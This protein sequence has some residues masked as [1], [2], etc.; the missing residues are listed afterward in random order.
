[1]YAFILAILGAICWGI[2]PMF[3]K[4]GLK[5]IHPLDGLAARTVVTVILVGGWALS[6]GTAARITSVPLRGW[7]FLAAEAFFATF[8]GDLAYYAAIKSGQVGPT[9]LVLSASPLITLWM[10][11]QFMGETLSALKLLG[12]GFLIVGVILIGV[13]STT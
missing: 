11:W 9:V 13:A 10:G 7:L 8:A 4:V 2:A 5:G 6:H 12:A 1:M 3:G